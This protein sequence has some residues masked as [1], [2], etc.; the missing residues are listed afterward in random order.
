MAQE[1]ARRCKTC[2]MAKSTK[3]PVRPKNR[4]RADSPFSLAYLDIAGPFSHSVTGD[5]YILGVRCDHTRW[6]AVTTIPTRRDVAHGLKTILDQ[7]Q[8]SVGRWVRNQ[9]GGVRSPIISTLQCDS[10][11][12]YRE[13]LS[14]SRAMQGS[15]HFM[16]MDLGVPTSLKRNYRK[17]LENPDGRS[18]GHADGSQT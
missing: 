4:V 6:V 9:D 16:Q 12:G 3:P 8:H 2:R 18:K 7:L 17:G 15:R 1:I 14:V 13:E 5:N 10:A 11:A